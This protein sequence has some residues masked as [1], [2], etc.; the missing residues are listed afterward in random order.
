M[1]AKRKVTLIGVSLFLLCLS[2]CW[3]QKSLGIGRRPYLPYV[4]ALTF[5]EAESAKMNQ[6][7]TEMP[8]LFKKLQKHNNVNADIIHKY[9]ES[10]IK[11]N[12]EQMK[13]LGYEEDEIKATIYAGLRKMGYPADDPLVKEFAPKAEATAVKDNESHG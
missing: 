4:P 8:D 13:A 9:N 3:D 5:T 6:W 7:S 12:M 10:A 11:V 1:Q 2:G